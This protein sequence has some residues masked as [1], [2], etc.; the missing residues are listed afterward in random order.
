MMHWYKFYS[1]SAEMV[2]GSFADL[3][4]TVKTLYE[5]H[6]EPKD[7]ALF[8]ATDNFKGGD[9][10]YLALPTTIE[11]YAAQVLWNF[12]PTICDKPSERVA[13]LVGNEETCDDLLR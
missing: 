1:S 9:H 4:T 7:F 11:E 8:V 5:V 10:F 13:L 6:D 3:L 12:A 2:G